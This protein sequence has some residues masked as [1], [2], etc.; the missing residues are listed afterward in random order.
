[1][2][3]LSSHIYRLVSL[4]RAPRLISRAPKRNDLMNQQ[5]LKILLVEDDPEVGLI[6]QMVL[7]KTKVPNELFV[8]GDGQKALDFLYHR[9][10]YS[11][12]RKAPQPDLILM[13]IDLPRISGLEVLRK[14]KVDK[15]LRR[16]PVTII[17]RSGCDAD[18]AE[19]YA[20]GANTY[21]QKPMGFDRFVRTIRSFYRYWTVLAKL[22]S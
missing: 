1:M 4:L 9:G 6:T 21:I 12:G 16:I 2:V 15:E 22:P 13:E 7:K 18:I 3:W 10:K 17:A 8:V 5:S 11:N 20:L 19:S 14:L